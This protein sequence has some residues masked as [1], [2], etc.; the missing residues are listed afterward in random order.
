MFGL[1]LF[2]WRTIALILLIPPRDAPNNVPFRV[3]DSRNETFSS[4]MLVMD[5]NHFLVEWLAYHYHVLPLRY[6]VVAVDP[7]SKTSPDKILDRFRKEGMTIDKWTDE[8]FMSDEERKEAEYFVERKFTSNN[9][10]IEPL[11]VEHRARQRVFYYKC[12]K[13]LKQ[14]GRSWTLLTDSDEFLHLNYKTI[15]S[16]KIKSPAISAPGSVM[17]FL[18]REL[19]RPGNNL[20]TP[21]VQIPRI[22]F[23]AIESNRREVRYRVPLAFDPLRFQTLRWRKHARA[24]NYQYNKISKTMIDLSRVEWDDIEPVESVHRPIKNICKRRRM[25][26]RSDDQVFVINHYLGS[27]QQYIYRDDARTGK[28]RS[29]EVSI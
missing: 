19:E 14:Q 1:I 29:K 10:N 5:D 28:E 6:L 25:Y 4:C 2:V 3:S 7:R 22:R 13:R 27:W 12:M 23:G 8:D 16:K 26:I 21:C 17:P 20:T 18:R 9:L 24:D 11:V 15:Q